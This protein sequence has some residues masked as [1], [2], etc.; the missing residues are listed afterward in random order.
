MFI[1]ITLELT[2]NSEKPLFKCKK[3]VINT[4]ELIYI[5]FFIK[6]VRCSENSVRFENSYGNWLPDGPNSVEILS[7]S[8]NYDMY[9][10]LWFDFFFFFFHFS[11]VP[12]HGG[13]VSKKKDSVL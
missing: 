12:G 1:K 7:H 3:P 4:T 6:C 13:P 2:Q 11:T 10:Y 5:Y 9:V 8:V